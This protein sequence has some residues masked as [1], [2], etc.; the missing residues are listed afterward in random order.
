MNIAEDKVGSVQQ[1]IDE[2]QKQ[3]EADIAQISQSYDPSS[4]TLE[5]ETIRPAK[6]N[7][8]VD[9]VSLLWLPYDA[10]GDRAW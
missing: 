4:L 8:S 2:L 7:V 6:T 9:S 3:L 1:E 5:T 10:R